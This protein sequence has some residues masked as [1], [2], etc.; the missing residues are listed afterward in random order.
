MSPHIINLLG[1]MRVRSGD[2]T[3]AEGAVGKP[4]ALLAYLVA[5]S[6]R[7]HSRERLAALFWPDQ[8]EPVARQN[9]RWAL[10]TLRRNLSDT[11]TDP[12]LLLIS[13]EQLQCNAASPWQVDLWR[14]ERVLADPTDAHEL[15]TALSTYQGELLEGIPTGTSEL[16]DTWL[17]TR[18]THIQRQVSSAFA[19]LIATTAAQGDYTTQAQLAQRWLQIEPWAEPAH[20]A[21]MQAFAG[22]GQRSAALRQFSICQEHL[23]AELGVAP[24]PA[25]VALYEAIRTSN[26]DPAPRSQPAPASSYDRNRQ[27]MIER[28]ERFWI[29]GV[30]TPTL[31]SLPDLRVPL[32]VAAG[33]QHPVTPGQVRPIS[34]IVEAFDQ[35]DGDLL[36]HGAAGAGKTILLLQLAAALLQRATADP[37][38]PIPVI[39][40]LS[41]WQ[42]KQRDLAGWLVEELHLRYQVPLR[43]GREW[44]AQDQILPLFDG[45]DEVEPADQAACVAALMRFRAEHW[46]GTLVVCGRDGIT[47]APLHLNGSVGIQPLALDDVHA[48][49]TAWGLPATLAAQLSSDPAW[50]R[51]VTTPLVLSLL[52]NASSNPAIQALPDAQRSTVAQQQLVEHYV[53]QML[54]RRSSMRNV[55]SET[56]ARWITWL[57]QMMDRH[58]TAIFLIEQLQPSWLTQRWQRRCFAAAEVMI[59]ALGLGLVAGLDEGLRLHFDGVLGGL[60]HGLIT[61]VSVAGGIGGAAAAG[62]ALLS[63]QQHVGSPRLRRA[64]LIGAL[65]AGIYGIT[66]ALLFDPAL[67]SGVGLAI[68]LVFLVILALVGREQPIAPVAHFQWSP[69]MA[70]QRLPFGLLAGTAS[71]LLFSLLDGVALGGAVGGAT[72]LA[73][74]A[75][76]GFTSSFANERPLPNAGIW[77]SA[78]TALRAALIIGGLGGLTFALAV[79]LL[80]WRTDALADGRLIFGQSSALLVGLINGIGPALIGATVGLIAFGGL[81]VV[82]HGLLRL[83]LWCG[84]DAPWNLAAFLDDTVAL[85]LLRRGGGGYLFL[86]R[87]ILEHFAQRDC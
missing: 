58:H 16:F 84:G 39:I 46:P 55:A 57:A 65:A 73:V 50:Q 25:T 78:Q 4:W 47:I 9:L 82:Q 63:E 80:T 1:P 48:R 75:G 60:R 71:G 31:A 34:T 40:N 85:Q 29:S 6:D 56:Y 54:A 45:L 44:V 61:G 18:R 62:A 33:M 81:A 86:H 51:V 76:L 79:G 67:G 21:L 72:A 14:L 28:V 23:A 69:T 2:E 36:I 5:E 32:T 30:L 41:F 8:P 43:I 11:T 38:H 27:R 59:V 22:Q 19:Q 68:G 42:P 26:P 13:R 83:M 52:R 53:A 66:T 70:L 7:P 74:T 20:R 64:G 24:E 37:Q 77:R 10:A 15:H 35:F 12:P 17:T 49:I 3:I 87:L